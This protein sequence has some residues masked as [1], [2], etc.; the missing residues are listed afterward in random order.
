MDRLWA[1]QVFVRVVE[2]SS[3]SRAAE[4]LDIANATVT[5]SVRN[6]E[7]YLGT[8]LLSRNTRT[9]RLTDAGESYFQRCI[10]LLRQVEE[11]ESSVREKKGEIAGQLSIES[12][13][14]FARALLCPALPAFAEQ[15][16]ELSVALRLTDHPEDLIASGTDVAIRID[17]VNDADLVARPLYLAH[18]V[19][20]ASPALLAANGTPKHPQDLDM[21]RCLGLFGQGRYAPAPWS[22]SR[23]SD[24][25][26][27]TP[28]GKLHF[29]STDALI[30][31]ALA[32]QGYI[33]VLDVFVNALISSGKLVELFPD[34]HTGGRTFYTVT[35]KS[36][37]VAPRTRAFIQFMLE[38]LDAQRRPP[39]QASIALHPGRHSRG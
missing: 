12:P 18:Y 13:A 1:M 25:V 31:A 23:D 10:E 7:T 16:P 15:H 24:S 35:P 5:S 4:S 17:S 34:W 20:C 28:R 32:D 6:L 27:L 14:A 29:N 11:A 30:Q 22:F 19:A 36:R 38:T 26:E 21:Q 3:F 37:F 9:L 39:P 33:Y 2:C 8:T